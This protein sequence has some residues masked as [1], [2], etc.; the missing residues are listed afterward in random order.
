[1]LANYFNYR[2]M[3]RMQIHPSA[4]SNFIPLIIHADGNITPTR[5][6]AD[7]CNGTFQRVSV[8]TSDTKRRHAL[9]GT[10]AGQAS[11]P[12]LR[13]PLPRPLDA[14]PDTVLPLM[15]LVSSYSPRRTPRRPQ[16]GEP[17]WI[18]TMH[19]GE[20]RGCTRA[21]GRLLDRCRAATHR[22]RQSSCDNS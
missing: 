12:S 15:R 4:V 11:S 6:S 17:C 13:I 20:P 14:I 8:Q 9:L 10:L 21:F 22:H 3:L 5:A 19:S 2:S 1:M 7:Q 18:C 16:W